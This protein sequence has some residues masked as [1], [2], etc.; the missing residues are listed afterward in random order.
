MGHVVD[1]DSLTETANAADFDINN[2]AGAEF[3]RGLS[4]AP[5]VDGFIQ[6]DAGLQ[7]LLQSGMEVKII[8]PERLFDHQQVESIELLE[9]LDL[10]ECV[11]RIGVATK[12]DFRPA[13]A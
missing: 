8:V 1:R 9:V 12:D 13:S 11:S 6:A 5:A 2:L 4:V 3:Q 7:L 10:I